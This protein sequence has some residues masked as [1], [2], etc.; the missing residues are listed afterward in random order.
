MKNHTSSLSRLAQAL[1]S[2]PQYRQLQALAGGEPL[3]MENLVEF[4]RALGGPCMLALTEESQ[5]YYV[6]GDRDVFRP[7]QYCAWFLENVG[8]KRLTRGVVQMSALHIESVVKRIG[9]VPTWPLGKALRHSLVKL[10]VDPVT[11]D[12]I[13]RF[14]AI[15]NDAK[16]KIDHP[17]YTHLFSVQDAILAYFVARQLGIQLYPLAKLATDIKTFGEMKVV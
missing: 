13:D 11:W 17:K 10:V 1:F 14:T 9:A 3:A 5:W 6:N 7:L 15:Y 8:R 16:H 2:P 12:Q 4:D